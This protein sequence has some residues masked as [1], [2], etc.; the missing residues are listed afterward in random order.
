MQPPIVIEMA[1][2]LAGIRPVEVTRDH[3]RVAIGVSRLR[4]GLAGHKSNLLSVGRPRYG[5]AL[6]WLRAVGALLFRQ[7]SPRRAVRMR[8]HQAMLV[9]NSAIEGRS[10]E[11]TSELQSR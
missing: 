4:A 10:E 9:A 3:H 6:I 8:N 7:E 1:V 2:A 11:H 5:R